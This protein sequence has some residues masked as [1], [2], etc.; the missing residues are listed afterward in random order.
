MNAAGIK[1]AGHESGQVHSGVRP[2][3][4]TQPPTG[5]DWGLKVHA[6]SHFKICTLL[7]IGL[8]F[9]A[10]RPV[11]AQQFNSDSYLSKPV[12][13]ATI[14]LTYGERNTMLMNTFSLLP[15]WEFTVSAY[16]YN[17]DRNPATDDGHSVSL[18][19]KYM[20]YENKAKTGGFAVKFGT[21]LDPGYLDTENR[22]NDAFRTYWTNAPLTLPFLNNKLS[23][24]IM[25]GASVN[26]DYGPEGDVVWN[27]TY[28]T[29]LAWYPTSPTWSMVGEIV[30]AEGEGTAPPEYRVG[31]RLEPNQY[32]VF[33]LTY[34]K[35]FEGGTNGAGW[36]IGMMLFSPPFFRIGGSK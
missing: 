16:L 31:L 18:Y 6:M 29:R 8:V 32:A 15:K 20:F 21:G 30:G 13:M 19:A 4:V 24:D 17:D 2:R 12:G 11:R 10:G 34:D 9:L 7:L 27:F 3:R 26:P 5:C 1:S 28:A 14:I 22:L 35:E 33:A 23:W 25:P 36:E